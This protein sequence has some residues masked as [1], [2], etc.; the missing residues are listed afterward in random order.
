[1]NDHVLPSPYFHIDPTQGSIVLGGNRLFQFDYVLPFD[2]P[3]HVIY[4][5]YIEP[6]VNACF[7]GTHTPQSPSII[8]H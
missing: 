3:Q 6:S 7:E 4:K 5:S 1:M 2:C 8:N